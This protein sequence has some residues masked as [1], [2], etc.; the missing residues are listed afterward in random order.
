M[1]TLYK[2]KGGKLLK[3]LTVMLTL[4]VMLGYLPGRA[5][6]DSLSQRVEDVEG[7]VESM[8]EPFLGL[9]SDVENLKKLKLSGYMQVR[10]DY[11]DSAK[12]GLDNEAKNSP[13]YSR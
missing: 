9:Q 6:E 2:G 12:S 10:F 7:K 1:Q 3:K 13:A 5:E 8:Q 4:V 11:A